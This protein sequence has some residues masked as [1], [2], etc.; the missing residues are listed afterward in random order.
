MAEKKRKNVRLI[1][2]CKK[3]IR[4]R[5]TALG[6]YRD[7]YAALIDRL[8]A[9][10]VQMDEIQAEYEADGRQLL[11]KHINKAG[12]ENTQTN[13]LLAAWLQT[14]AQA[15]ALERE[16][17]L[18]PAAMRKAGETGRKNDAGKAANI[19]ASYGGE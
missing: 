3:T 4:A 11:V 5:M 18:T 17:L 9:L 19:L 14:Q 16:L 8:A 2:S 1:T 7:Q 10:Y 13:P 6:T 12:A 15:L